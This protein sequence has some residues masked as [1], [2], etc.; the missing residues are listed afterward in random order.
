ML[1]LQCIIYA[2]QFKHSFICTQLLSDMISLFIAAPP[3]VQSTATPSPS[4]MQA[5]VIL[6]AS[7][8]DFQLYSPPRAKVA[9]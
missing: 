6:H 4:V 8:T 1:C 7:C 9:Y 3:P 5:G 2:S